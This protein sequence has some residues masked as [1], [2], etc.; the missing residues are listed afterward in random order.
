M[1]GINARVFPS[2]N[3]HKLKSINWLMF[4]IET[5]FSGCGN[6]LPRTLQDWAFLS[7]GTQPTEWAYPAW[8]DS[9]MLKHK[10]SLF[11]LRQ[12]NSQGQPCS[13]I[14]YSQFKFSLCPTCFT[15]L[16]QT[17]FLGEL[18]CTQ[19]SNLSVYFLEL[20]FGPG[21][22]LG[23]LVVMGTAEPVSFFI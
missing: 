10:C 15:L 20:C 2:W 9:Y 5:P 19:T 12:D 13:K 23:I 17:T 22:L 4:F 18:P 6:V 8:N 21:I 3:P 1:K 14:I 16:S 11:A 7:N